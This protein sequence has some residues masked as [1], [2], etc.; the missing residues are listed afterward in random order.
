MAD[1]KQSGARPLDIVIV[2]AGIG[3]LSA[4]IFLRQQ[5]HNVTLLEQ[6]SF[7]NELGAAVHLAPNA[8]ALVRRMGLYAEEIGAN[9]TLKMT[10]YLPN[11]KVLFSSDLAEQNKRWPHPWLLAH[12][13]HLHSEFKR[14]ATTEEGKGKPVALRTSTRV[15]DVSGD[16]IVTLES[17][18]QISADVVVGADG[19]HSRTRYAI[20]GSAGVNVF[21][22]GKSAF[23]FL[24]SRQKALDDADTRKFAQNE[25]EM[26]IVMGRDRRVVIYPTADNTLLN[27]VCI[28]PTSE[29]EAKKED[30]GDWNQVG[31]KDKMLDVYKDFEPALIKLLSMADEETLKVWELLDMAQLPTWTDG[32]LVL[33]GDA[34]HPFTPHQGQGAGQAIEDGASLAVVLPLGSSV[35]EIPERLKLYEKCRY[36]RASRIQEYSRIAGKDLGDGPPLD[37][38]E[39]A[40]YNFGHDEWDA[41]TEALRKWTNETRA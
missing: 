8:N 37:I 41:S 31:H 16:G 3:G 21:G 1:G 13:V 23:R 18:E 29:S 35:E 12:R 34:A 40:E 14:R 7:S 33:I 4:A 36:E 25:G 28:H 38:H 24:L 30:S 6:S 39:Y 20:P 32:R 27:F 19:V 5:G 26:Q 22:S 11:G 2:G 10:Q 15:K 9:P 17:G